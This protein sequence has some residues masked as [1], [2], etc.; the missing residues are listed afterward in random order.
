MIIYLLDTSTASHVIRGDRPA[1]AER[2]LAAPHK[3]IAISVITEAELRYGLVKRS[4]PVNLCRRVER[5]LL[6]VIILPWNREL[7]HA[8]ASLRVMREARGAVLAPMDMLIAAHAKA[9]DAIL[10]TSDAAFGFYPAGLR[11]ED[12]NSDR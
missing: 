3:S 2:V 4:S 5:F 12:W 10:V 11:L 7:T 6:Q 8:Y 1:V 9:I